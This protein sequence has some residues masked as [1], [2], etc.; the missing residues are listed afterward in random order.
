MVDASRQSE[1]CCASG[2]AAP[3]RVAASKRACVSFLRA[4]GYGFFTSHPLLTLAQLR[5]ALRD[6]REPSVASDVAQG[7]LGCGHLLPGPSCGACH[8]P[9]QDIVEGMDLIRFS[10]GAQELPESDFIHRCYH[11]AQEPAVRAKC[12][13]CHNLIPQLHRVDMVRVRFSLDRLTRLCSRCDRWLSCCGGQRCTRWAAERPGTGQKLCAECLV[14]L[15]NEVPLAF[16]VNDVAVLPLGSAVSVLQVLRYTVQVRLAIG[17]TDLGQFIVYPMDAGSV[18]DWL[19]ELVFRVTEA[20]HLES[21]VAPNGKTVL[22]H[23]ILHNQG[24]GRL[25]TGCSPARHS[26]DEA[27]AAAA[28]WTLSPVLVVPGALGTSRWPLVAATAAFLDDPAAPHPRAGDIGLHLVHH[29]MTAG[30]HRCYFCIL[31][32]ISIQK[33]PPRSR[34]HAPFLRRHSCICAGTDDDTCR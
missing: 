24:T 6:C 11:F 3:R 12:S 17:G 33:L 13:S 28:L 26:E 14:D 19:Y 16:Q 30:Q 23:N 20:V 15:R 34:M 9:V 2:L 5:D 21:R 4:N 25:G 8:V 27:W 29:G 31:E 32:D 18:S 22:R 10:T 7:A 1:A